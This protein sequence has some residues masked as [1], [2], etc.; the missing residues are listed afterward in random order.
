MHTSAQKID[1]EPPCFYGMLVTHYFRTGLDGLCRE[2]LHDWDFGPDDF[3]L[4]WGCAVAWVLGIGAAD[5]SDFEHHVSSAVV[6]AKMDANVL[7][8]IPLRRKIQCA[9]PNSEVIGGSYG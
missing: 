8:A 9:G 3:D 4:R 1:E 6:P 2:A 5:V 7:H